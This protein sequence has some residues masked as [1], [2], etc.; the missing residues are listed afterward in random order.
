MNRGRHTEDR[1]T[2]APDVSPRSISTPSL[3]ASLSLPAASQTDPGRTEETRSIE[4][5]DRDRLDVAEP[6]LA[7]SRGRTERTG[8]KETIDGDREV[9]E[10]AHLTD[11]ERA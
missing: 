8:D 7:T 9:D 4:T 1:F 2:A 5:V 10:I 3:Y 6:S 11:F